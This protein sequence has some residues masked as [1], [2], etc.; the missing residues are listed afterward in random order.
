MVVIVITCPNTSTLRLPATAA[1]WK[2]NYT[3]SVRH[4]AL[5]RHKMCLPIIS[6]AFIEPT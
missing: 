4:G 2:A 5:V 1:I 6:V 3:T